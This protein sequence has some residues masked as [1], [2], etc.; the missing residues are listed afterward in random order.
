MFFWAVNSV[1][2]LFAF[3]N[4][5]DPDWFLW[6]TTYLAVPAATVAYRQNLI[7]KK[8]LKALLFYLFFVF[9]VSFFG[10]VEILDQSSDTTLN[11]KEPNREAV[12]AL[13]AMAWVFWTSNR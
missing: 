11:M 12:G 8:A 2:V 7:N 1:F 5:N 9:V 4:Y 6:I 13:I 3:L 10:F